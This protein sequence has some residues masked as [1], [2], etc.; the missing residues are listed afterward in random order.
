[1][2]DR[3]DEIDE[4]LA[5]RGSL[6]GW[7]MRNAADYSDKWFDSPGS[8]FNVYYV[9]KA[10]GAH[11]CRTIIEAKAWHTWKNQ[12]SGIREGKQRWYCKVCGTKYKTTWGVIVE[13]ILDRKKYNLPEWKDDGD[14]FE[15]KGKSIK[16]HLPLYMTA[17]ILENDMHFDIKCLCVERDF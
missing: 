13:L 6:N 8:T 5:W 17:D 12:M 2:M 15:I 10:G 16:N 3:I 14:N 7:Q 1:M 4:P 9:C 11:E